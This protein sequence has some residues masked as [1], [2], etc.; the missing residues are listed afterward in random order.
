[1]AH[2]AAKLDAGVD[3]HDLRLAALHCACAL[4][5][6]TG[7]KYEFTGTAFTMI[8]NAREFGAFQALE[9]AWRKRV[10]S[11]RDRYLAALS[12]A[13]Q[14]RQLAHAG[15]WRGPSTVRLLRSFTDLVMR[16]TIPPEEE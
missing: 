5:R 1:M 13:G 3:M 7:E 8:S 6:K 10:E 9:D 14:S 11:A 15:G 12:Q 16:G 2:A 4:C